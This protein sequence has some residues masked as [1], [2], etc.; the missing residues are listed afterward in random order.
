MPENKHEK[1]IKIVVRTVVGITVV[2][3]LYRA[4]MGVEPVACYK[5]SPL[6]DKMTCLE[7][8]GDFWEPKKRGF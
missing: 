1:L 6:R 3:I 2:V 5:Y 8:G 7:L 4:L